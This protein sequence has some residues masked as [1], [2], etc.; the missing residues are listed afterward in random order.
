MQDQK[1]RTP[2]LALPY[3]KCDSHPASM[4]ATAPKSRLAG[5][6]RI[7]HRMQ[8]LEFS[9]RSQGPK[10]WLTYGRAPG[11]DGEEWAAMATLDTAKPL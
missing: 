2:R 5:R 9:K 10:L 1:T 4:L 6:T 3:S 11:K 8:I 7:Q